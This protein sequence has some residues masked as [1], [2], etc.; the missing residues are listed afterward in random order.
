MNVKT[1]SVTVAGLTLL[2]SSL[3]GV[4]P[5][6]AASFTTFFMPSIIICLQEARTCRRRTTPPIPSATSP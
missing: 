4:T 5:A 3:L 6:S 1:T 2:A